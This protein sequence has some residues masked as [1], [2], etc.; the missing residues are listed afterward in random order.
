MTWQQQRSWAHGW[1]A[2]GVGGYAMLCKA[3]RTGTLYMHEHVSLHV[4]LHMF[5]AMRAGKQP[6]VGMCE[7]AHLRKHELP[8]VPRA[9]VA[10]ALYEQVMLH[11]LG[12]CSE[13]VQ[14]ISSWPL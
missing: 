1:L 4:S 6:D 11:V 10:M 7:F 5:H 12:L 3:M 8:P 9:Q 14:R 13:K 2:A